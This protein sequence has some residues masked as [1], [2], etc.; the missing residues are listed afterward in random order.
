M[1]R[2]VVEVV[3]VTTPALPLL[4]SRQLSG[5]TSELGCGVEARRGE[6]VVGE[7]S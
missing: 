3:E 1:S 5:G 2:E 6:Y 4:P 7:E